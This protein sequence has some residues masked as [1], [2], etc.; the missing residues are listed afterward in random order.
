MA[1]KRGDASAE[2]RAIYKE[3]ILPLMEENDKGKVVVI[4]VNSG[5]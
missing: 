2:G 3:K 5:E 4:D 1:F